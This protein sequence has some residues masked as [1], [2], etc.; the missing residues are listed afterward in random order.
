MG[1]IHGDDD[2]GT[3]WFVFDSGGCIHTGRYVCDLPVVHVKSREVAHIF[4]LQPIPVNAMPPPN[5]MS[6]V[7]LHVPS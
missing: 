2:E 3:S 1:E 6:Y 5:E 7:F 4:L